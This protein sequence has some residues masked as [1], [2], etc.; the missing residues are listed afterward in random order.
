M[1]AC[2]MPNQL[3]RVQPIWSTA[4]DQIGSTLGNWFGMP[5]ADIDQVFPNLAN[6]STKN[7]GFMV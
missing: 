1:S 2:G 4:V 6:F 3:P 7:L 5:Q